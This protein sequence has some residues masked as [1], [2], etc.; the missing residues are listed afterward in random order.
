MSETFDA[1]FPDV[2]VPTNAWQ[3]ADSAQYRLLRKGA[4]RALSAVDLIICATA[5]VRGL[6]I[7]H[8]DSDFAT[9]ARH[10]THV[11]ERRVDEYPTG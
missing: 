3:W 7:L 10:L 11:R 2:T 6:V 9:A 8:D 1:L 5:A 4:H